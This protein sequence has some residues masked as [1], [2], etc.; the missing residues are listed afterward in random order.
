MSLKNRFL[1]TVRCFFIPNSSSPANS[2]LDPDEYLTPTTLQWCQQQLAQLN[3]ITSPAGS[4]FIPRLDH[5]RVP[6]YYK[7]LIHTARVHHGSDEDPR[8]ELA[9]KPRGGY[10]WNPRH[11]VAEDLAAEDLAAEDLAEG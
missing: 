2:I 11:E 1:T 4:D 3:L 6:D 10:G 5:F 7:S 8:L 9:A